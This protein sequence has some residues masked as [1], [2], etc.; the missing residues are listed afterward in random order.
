[1]PL[2]VVLAEDS[3]LMRDGLVGVLTRF[4]HQV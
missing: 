2:T 3:P 4:G 1:M